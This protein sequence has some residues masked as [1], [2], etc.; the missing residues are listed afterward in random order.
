MENQWTEFAECLR[1]IRSRSPYPVKSDFS[2]AS[3]MSRRMYLHYEDGERL[4]RPK[5]LEQMI[6]QCRI[7]TQDADKLRDVWNRSKAEQAGVK[8]NPLAPDI[9]VSELSERVVKE[10]EYELKRTNIRLTPRT[11]RVCKRRIAMILSDTLGV[12]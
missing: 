12:T 1:Y 10:V 8:I 5:S 3:G 11:R 7:S 2:A 9:N 6:L 4:P